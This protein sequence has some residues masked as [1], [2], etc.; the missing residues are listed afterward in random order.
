[1]KQLLL[2]CLA[3]PAVGQPAF[4]VAS[5]RPA[6]FR[7]PTIA[8]DPGRVTF[9]AVTWKTPIGRAYSVKDYQVREPEWIANAAYVVQATMPADTSDAIAWQMLQAL[10][11]GALPVGVCGGR[12]KRWRGDRQPGFGA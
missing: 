1:M 11:A 2:L 4:T 3:I 5:V 10:L 6:E 12:P 9:H 8:I 7:K